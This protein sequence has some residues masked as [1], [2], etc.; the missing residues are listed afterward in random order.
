[1]T[2]GDAVTKKFVVEAFGVLSQLVRK[3]RTASG[4]VAV[5]VGTR[6]GRQVEQVEHFGPAQPT[7]GSRRCWLRRVSGC[8]R[9]RTSWTW[10]PCRHHRPLE[11]VTELPQTDAHPG[12]RL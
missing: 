10:A 9:V 5:L 11:L 8:H 7:H 12:A 3:V 2:G 6:R 1:V 4:A